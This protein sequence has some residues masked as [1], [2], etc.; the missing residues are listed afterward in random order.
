MKNNK[1]MLS[2]WLALSLFCPSLLL[3]IGCGP[4]NRPE[5]LPSLSPCT[6]TVTQQEK[7]LAD[8]SV[9]LIPKFES[10]WPVTGLTDASGNA[11]MV[12]YGQFKGAPLGEYT[13]VITKNESKSEGNADEY[14]SGITEIFSLVDV[15]YTKP[16]TSTLE[17]TVEKKR[18]TKK[19]ELGG[20][21]HVLVDTIRPGT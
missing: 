10:P 3:T 15:Q 11:V 6:I 4:S 21:V 14:S 17:I 5:G 2:M 1:Q 7:P 18:N 9:Q 19:C 13:V 8:A 20:P 12:T 16:E